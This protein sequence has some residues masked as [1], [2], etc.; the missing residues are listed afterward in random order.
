M[1]LPRAATE[2]APGRC[3]SPRRGPAAEPERELGTAEAGWGEEVPMCPADAPDEAVLVRIEGAGLGGSGAPAV[4][5]L[6]AGA[7]PTSGW[8]ERAFACIAAV[9]GEGL[10]LHRAP[11]EL[12][13]DG[14]FALAP[15]AGRIAVTKGDRERRWSASCGTSSSRCRSTARPHRV[16]PC[17]GSSSPAAPASSAP[18]SLWRS[19]ARHPDWELVCARQ[20]QAARL[21]AQPAAPARRPAWSSCTATSASPPTCAALEPDRRA[22]RVL[23]RAVGAGRRAT[24]PTDYVVHTNLAR[25]LPLPRA[26][27]PRRRAARVPLDQPRLPG[28]RAR[29]GRATRRPRRASSSPPSRSCRASR[30]PGSPRT[31]RSRARARSTA[32]RSSRPSC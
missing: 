17:A 31:S 7:A 21:R 32:P 11:P 9:A 30:R 12:D 1:S 13:H 18:T 5:L 6:Q 15:N 28:G 4:D 10:L 20:P 25:R 3:S 19:R 8:T 23:G 22:R 24:A 29:A 16:C 14:A 2:R 27:A 26:R